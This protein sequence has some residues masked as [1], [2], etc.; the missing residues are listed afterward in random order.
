MI[1]LEKINTIEKMSIVI[2]GQI[3]IIYQIDIIIIRFSQ[4]KRNLTKIKKT[5]NAGTRGYDFYKAK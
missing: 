5:I 4:P 2:I 1:I 3:K